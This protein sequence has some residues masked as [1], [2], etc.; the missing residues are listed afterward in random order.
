MDWTV[1]NPQII[2]LLSNNKQQILTTER[3]ALWGSMVFCLKI[4]L[5]IEQLSNTV[6]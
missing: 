6:S 2:D 4:T 5:I 3:L 1:Q